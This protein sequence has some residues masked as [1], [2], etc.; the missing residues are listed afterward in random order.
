MDYHLFL[1][2]VFVSCCCVGAAPFMRQL[3]TLQQTLQKKPNYS[4]IV[5]NAVDLCKAAES[6][7]LAIHETQ[8]SGRSKATDTLKEQDPSP[9]SVLCALEL[10]YELL[11]QGLNKLASSAEGRK[12]EGHLVY[13]LVSL[14]ETILRALE[15]RSKTTA[16]LEEEN[17][18]QR[19]QAK[20]QKQAAKS[21]KQERTPTTKP[22][23]EDQVSQG[24][25]RLL[26]A[27]M[28]LSGSNS[29][30]THRDLLEGYLFVLLSRV[31]KILCVFE[32]RDLLLRPDLRAA[33][34][35]LPMPQGLLQADTDD[36]AM[37][38]AE[39][40]AKYLTWLL[41]RAMAVVYSLSMKSASSNNNAANNKNNNGTVEEE[42]PNGP[43][44]R[45][46]KRKLQSTLLKAVFGEEH[47]AFV[48]RL[49]RPRLLPE[50]ALAQ[51][52]AAEESALD[53]FP[54]EVWRLLGWDMLAEVK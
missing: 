42:G 22:D 33:P 25:V 21:N 13:H 36:A 28:L 54:R 5:L 4:V 9:I 47:P 24:I 2:F 26:A 35:K 44:L 16:K 18:P 48:E 37:R 30:A 40:E 46:A 6:A 8:A 53:W 20:K 31:G 39:M 52:R 32:F 3:Y 12:H 10:A 43:L 15:Q 49:K 50:A 1:V 7:V 19:K 29:V 27:M 38:A 41:E 45:F 17:S 14:F 34:D 51:P 11:C 23:D